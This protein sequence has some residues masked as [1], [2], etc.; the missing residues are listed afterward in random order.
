LELRNQ[1]AVFMALASRLQGRQE[2]AT[3]MGMLERNLSHIIRSIRD[4][5]HELSMARYPFGHA[6]ADPTLA[7]YLVSGEF[8]DRD[9]NAVL[10]AA[11]ELVEGFPRLYVRMLGR[12]VALAEEIEAAFGL[13]QLPEPP[14]K[15][16]PSTEP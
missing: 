16:E 3:L 14:P 7:E 6:K 13:P 10:G 8:D 11:N 5:Q 15:P 4:M 12:L 9:W 1:L 2:N